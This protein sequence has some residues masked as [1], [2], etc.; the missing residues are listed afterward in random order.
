MALLFTPVC[1]CMNDKE[2]KKEKKE[3]VDKFLRTTHAIAHLCMEPVKNQGKSFKPPDRPKITEDSMTA[4]THITYFRSGF[5]PET[6]N[7]LP[8][9]NNGAV[10]GIMTIHLCLKAVYRKLD[11]PVNRP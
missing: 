4:N 1:L 5:E 8:C 7:K 2:H 11:C 10:S 9:L 6:F 3:F